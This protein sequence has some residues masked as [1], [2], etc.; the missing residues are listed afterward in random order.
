MLKDYYCDPHVQARLIEFLG[1]ASLGEA[2]SLFVTSN[3]H[4]SHAWYEPQPLSDLCRLLDEGRDVARSLWDRSSLIA[5]LDIEYVN[6]DNPAEPYLEPA[7]TFAV[8]RP[9]VRAIQETLL[10]Y[11]IAPL[12]LLSGRGH[13]L[14]GEFGAVHRHS[15]R[16][17]GWAESPARCARSTPNRSRQRANLWHSL[18]A[19]RSR[20]WG[21]LWNL[22]PINRCESRTAI[23]KSRLH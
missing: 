19:L 11:G 3:G 1:G 6:F 16:W 8:Q 9:V 18:S 14:C 10:H 21:W 13:I 7:R 17:R 23:P 15:N 12:H 4:S 22:S 5:H 20:D 2:T